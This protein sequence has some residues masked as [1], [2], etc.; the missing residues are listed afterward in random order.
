MITMLTEVY[1]DH[2]HYSVQRA[3]EVIWHRKEFFGRDAAHRAGG[4]AFAA[5]CAEQERQARLAAGPDERV[6]E[7]FIE[8]TQRSF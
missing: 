8:V 5:A 6:E 1:R 7:R 4:P 3:D 2:V